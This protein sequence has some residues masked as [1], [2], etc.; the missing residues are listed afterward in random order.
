LT[1][2]V[3]L[4]ND[5]VRSDGFS[6]KSKKVSSKSSMLMVNY[7]VEGLVWSDLGGV[8]NP[9]SLDSQPQ[10]YG[11]SIRSSERDVDRWADWILVILF[12]A[13]R[14]LRFHCEPLLWTDTE[15]DSV[16]IKPS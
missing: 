5:D 7:K 14:Y 13:L 9:P 8:R 1:S 15:F 4:T 2:A 12:V 11:F 3:L 16:G 10:S 6:S